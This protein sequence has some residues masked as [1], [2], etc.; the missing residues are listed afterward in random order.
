MSE[1]EEKCCVLMVT[2]MDCND[3]HVTRPAAHEWA[4]A[5]IRHI[6]QSTGETLEGQLKAAIPLTSVINGFLF[7][8]ILMDV[9]E[10]LIQRALVPGMQQRQCKV[11]IMERQIAEADRKRANVRMA[12][13][14][15]RA[16]DLADTEK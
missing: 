15:K 4:T 3:T 14:K 10:E 5:L 12:Q 1:D 8:V 9:P 6:C 2:R 13:V 16:H 11:K 7:K